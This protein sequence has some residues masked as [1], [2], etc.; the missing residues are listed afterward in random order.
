MER[1]YTPVEQ[2]QNLLRFRLIIANKIRAR[3]KKRIR[4]V[5]KGGCVLIRPGTWKRAEDWMRNTS[6]PHPE[7]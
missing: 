7:R 1:K 5:L 3:R 4:C 2:A 6:S